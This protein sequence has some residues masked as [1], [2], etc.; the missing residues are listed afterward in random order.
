MGGGGK[1]VG[2]WGNLGGNTK[3]VVTYALAPNRQRTFAGAVDVWTLLF[4][5]N[6]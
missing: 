2:W 3:G 5:N 1:Y 4:E 6:S